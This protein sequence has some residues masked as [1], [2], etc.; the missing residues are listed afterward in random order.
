MTK[1]LIATDCYLP[2]WDG[3][4]RFL[5]EMVPRL[6]D[7]FEITIV[8][9]DFPGDN[10]GEIQGVNILRIPLMKRQF[11]DYTPAKINRSLIKKLV[12]ENDIVWSQSI[13]TIGAFSITYG[14]KY[15]K[16][17]VAY[18]HSLEWDL[19]TKALS[20][21]YIFE[22]AVNFFTRSVA[23][24]LY[25]K[26]NLLM[27]SHDKITKEL[28]QKGIHAKKE[29]VKLGVNINTFIPPKN[30]EEAKKIIGLNQNKK[31]IGYVGRIAR[32][33]DL[34]TLYKG[35][36]RL[37]QTNQ[38]IQLLVVGKGVKEVEEKLKKDPSVFF[39]GKQDNPV[40]YYQAM[41]IYVLPSLLE[42]TSLTTLE[43]MSCG[44]ACLVTPVGYIKEYIKRNYNGLFFP[45]KNPYVLAK[46]LQFLIENEELIEKLGKNARRTVVEK[47]SWEKTGQKV[48]ELLKKL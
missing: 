42:T 45:R 3:I 39:A 43:A 21:P 36:K 40:P 17:V 46:K 41:D 20:P 38:N 26:C 2:R 28:S 7:D 27:V 14:R 32:E 47:F 11:G 9:P 30:K 22:G 44:V 33:K 19:V 34:F 15:K 31:I 23:K 18:I 25:N 16:H 10:K 35:F 24:S 1:L 12:K 37:Q 6:K 48:N 4:A 13:G 8:A 29:V 5:I